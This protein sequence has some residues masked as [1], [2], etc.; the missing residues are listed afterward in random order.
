M[1]A[2]ECQHRFHGRSLKLLEAHDARVDRDLLAL[3][4]AHRAQDLAKPKAR[5][6]VVVEQGLPG[7]LEALFRDRGVIDEV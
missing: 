3:P 7:G 5:G 2:V 4:G 6:A 1:V